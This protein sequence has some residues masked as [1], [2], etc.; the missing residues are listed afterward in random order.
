MP[1]KP[2]PQQPDLPYEAGTWNK[3]PRWQCKLC[4]WDT[5]EGEAAMLQ[6]IMERHAPA[7]ERVPLKVPLYDRYGN[8]IEEREV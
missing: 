5:L 8:L 1:K 6:H 4:S 2:E 3:L 7:P